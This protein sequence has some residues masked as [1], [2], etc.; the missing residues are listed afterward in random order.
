MAG[1]VTRSRSRPGQAVLG[2]HAYPPYRQAVP[3]CVVVRQAGL[4]DPGRGVSVHRAIRYFL[5]GLQC[6]GDA[7]IANRGAAG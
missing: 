5:A 2:R 4:V 7:W 3:R 6:H 1:L